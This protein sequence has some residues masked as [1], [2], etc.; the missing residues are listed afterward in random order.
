MSHKLHTYLPPRNHVQTHGLPYK[1]K[2]STVSI[3][4]CYLIKLYVPN[5]D[6]WMDFPS[7]SIKK[8]IIKGNN[9]R[10]DLRGVEG[11]IVR[12]EKGA[13][14]RSLMTITIT[15]FGFAPSPQIVAPRCDVR[16]FRSKFPG[17]LPFDPMVQAPCAACEPGTNRPILSSN[18]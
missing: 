8:S 9:I 2:G 4:Y 14:K 3:C 11:L 16:F 1:F 6:E 17:F 13:E 15:Y 7:W 10:K 5:P 12:A 18:F